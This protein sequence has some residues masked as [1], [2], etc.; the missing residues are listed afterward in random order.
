MVPDIFGVTRIDGVYW[1]LLPELMFYG[2]ILGLL[3]IK[4]LKIIEL[5]CIVWLSLILI[6]SFH[7][8]PPLRVLLNLRFGHLFIIGICFYKIKMKES[9][10]LHHT[11]IILAF[12]VSFVIGGSIEKQVA[13]LLFI[14]IFYLVAYDKL[15]WFKFAPL[16]KLGEISYALYLIHQFIGYLIINRLIN[17]G[18]DNS[19][20]LLV[21]PTITTIGIAYLISMYVEKPIQ[22]VLKKGWDRF[23][24]RTP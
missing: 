11:L 2:L 21:I 1:S 10:W 22:F 18:V 12:S 3:I 15:K 8:S 7:D 24:E 16:V 6:N 14:G 9:S 17:A 20:L 13:L 23:H 5:V 4:K 19:I